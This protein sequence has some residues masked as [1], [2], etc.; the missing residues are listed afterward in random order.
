MAIA[1]GGIANAGVAAG[2]IGNA[3]GAIYDLTLDSDRSIELDK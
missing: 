2:G 1:I 3:S